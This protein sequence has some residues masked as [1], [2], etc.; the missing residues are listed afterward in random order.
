MRIILEEIAPKLSDS[1]VAELRSLITDIEETIS[2]EAAG[3]ALAESP[4]RTDIDTTS[5]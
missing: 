4:S 2:K 5:D 1:S 3:R